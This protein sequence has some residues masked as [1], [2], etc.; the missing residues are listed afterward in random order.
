M[1]E[2]AAGTHGTAPVVLIV[3]GGFAGLDVAKGLRDA[4][5]SVILVDR[6]NYHLFQPLLYQVATAVLSPA[7]IASPIRNILKNQKNAEVIL[8]DLE[9]VDPAAG[10]AHFQGTSVHYDYLVLAMGVTHSYFG[11]EDWE[12]VAPGLKTVDDALELRRRVLLAFEE[13]ERE[14]DDES[15]RGKLT[16]VV[17]G[18]GP[19]GVEMAGALKEIAARSIPHDFRYIDTTTARVILVEAGERLLGGLPQPLGE[20]ARR[21]LERMGVEVRLGSRVT[22]IDREAV[23]IGEE[24]LA[25]QNV[26]WAAGVQGTPAARTLGVKLDGSGRIVVGPDLAI[27]DHPE[28]F[29]AGDLAHVEDPR[30]GETVPGLAPAAKQ[31]GRHVARIIRDESKAGPAA[32]REPFRYRDKGTMATIGRFKAVAA[33]RKWN[34]AGTFAWLLWSF[35]HIYFLVGFRRRLFVMLSWMWNYLSF[36]KGAR[37]IT[38]YPQLRIKRPRHA[39]EPRGAVGRRKKAGSPEETEDASPYEDR[40]PE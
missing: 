20:R 37:L 35:I 17:V 16:F 4:P 10:M 23:S 39:A 2:P 40:R 3:G 8:D 29:V 14:E 30:S 26:I 28:I 13:A 34:F 18:G 21:D 12:A 15:R 36:H 25:T 33:V 19:T 27:P 11:H 6:H 38:G 22:G 1:T 9:R 5:V 31:M 32:P 24:R 7:D